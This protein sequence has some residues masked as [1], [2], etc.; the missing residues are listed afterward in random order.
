MQIL[1]GMLAFYILPSPLILLQVYLV[2]ISSIMTIL[3]LTMLPP[4]TCWLLLGVLVL[5][6]LVAVL[7]PF[8]PLGLLID[9]VEKRQRNNEKVDIPAIMIYSTMVYFT[10]SM[11]ELSKQQQQS[12]QA[13]TSQQYQQASISLQSQQPNSTQQAS[14]TQQS[15]QINST[16][17]SQQPNSTQQSTSTQQTKNQNDTMKKS[18]GKRKPKRGSRPKLGLGDFIFY[19]L[20]VG[21]TTQMATLLTAIF[22]AFTIIFGLM[23]TLFLLTYYQKALPALPIS[24]TLAIIV[25]LIA[26]FLSEPFCQILNCNIILI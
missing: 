25:V 20:L 12:Q 7:A 3:I 22:A 17:Q 4:I 19:G 18:A 21:K 9:L 26:H 2:Y 13:S 11:A 10:M 15:I 6:D 24:L 14:F 5:W 1:L 8:G 16:Q 23:W